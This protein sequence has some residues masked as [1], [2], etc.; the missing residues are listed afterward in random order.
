MYRRC[1]KMNWDH[2]TFCSY[3]KRTILLCAAGLCLIAPWAIVPFILTYIIKENKRL[4]NVYAVIL[5][6]AVLLCVGAVFDMTFELF[7]YD[8]GITSLDIWEISNWQV[9]KL[10]HVTRLRGAFVF[11]FAGIVNQWGTNYLRNADDWMI[12]K[13]HRDQEKQIKKVDKLPFS[14]SKEHVCN[15]GTTGS[16][17]TTYGLIEHVKPAIENGEPL[18]IISGKNGADDDKSLLRQTQRLAKKYKRKMAIVSTRPEFK[19]KYNPFRNFSVTETVDALCSMSEFS[20][21]HYEKAFRNYMGTLLEAMQLAK[22]PF[23]LQ[24]IIQYYNWDDFAELLRLMK[25]NNAITDEQIKEYMKAKDYAEI[26]KDSKS[27]FEDLLKG[28]GGNIL[29]INGISAKKCLEDGYIFFMDLDSFKY[30]A[31]TRALGALA[32]YDVRECMSSLPQKRRCKVFLDEL[33]Y[34]CNETLEV[35]FAQA[36]STNYQLICSFQNLAQLKKVS[37]NFKDIIIGNCN[38]FAIM[39]VNGSDAEEMA[40][41]FGTYNTVDTTRKSAA[42]DLDDADAGSKRNVNKFRVA[43]DRIRDLKSLT[44]IYINKERDNVVYQATLDPSVL[45][46]IPQ[47]GTPQNGKSKPSRTRRSNDRMGQTNHTKSKRN[48]SKS[49]RQ[50]S[51]KQRYK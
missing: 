46:K 41:I 39:R 24:T 10:F 31:F 49:N 36:R 47:K 6:G 1:M 37:E 14:E 21:Q 18:I 38:A 4:R 45:P 44:V 34:Y 50:S 15:A 35:C 11:S 23:S 51:I 9:E 43:P 3:M 20:E 5:W 40:S 48:N 33:G 7:L 28:E 30:Q 22:I 19:N 16:G 25:K 12:Q 17:K 26:A 13:E 8:I 2:V 42:A 29:G 27:R 32:I